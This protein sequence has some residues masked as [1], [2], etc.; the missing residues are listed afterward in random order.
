MMAAEDNTLYP[1]S[2][3]TTVIVGLGK[4][5]LSCAK[6]LVSRGEPFVVVDS[7]KEPPYVKE[8]LSIA[9]NVECY[10][11]KFDPYIFEQ[12][13]RLI[14]SPGI[15]IKET[16]ISE[17]TSQGAEITGDVAL[18]A[19]NANAP[20]VAITGSNGKS[21]VTTLLG[22]MA[23]KSN[24]SAVLGGNLGMPA[25][26]LLVGS[27]GSDDESLPKTPEYYVLELSS[28]QLETTP[29]LHAHAAVV[30]NISEDHMDRYANLQEYIDAKQK[31]YNQ[32]RNVVFNRDDSLVTEIINSMDAAS[33]SSDVSIG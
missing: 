25:L 18:F 6:F 5:G 4:T 8:L 21:T 10:F 22:E 20:I 28:F 11:G 27:V 19:D 29:Q 23:G 13:K 12:A 16:V 9:P 30:L 24:V 33:A 3:T 17:A 14:V 2:R 1:D 31:V 7:R 15:S 26:D 32:C